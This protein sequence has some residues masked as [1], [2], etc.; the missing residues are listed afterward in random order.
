MTDPFSDFGTPPKR[1]GGPPD[2]VPATPAPIDP[3]TQVSGPVRSGDS[4]T[5]IED[6]RDRINAL[7]VAPPKSTTPVHIFADPG[8]RPS[9]TLIGG[10]ITLQGAISQATP[11]TDDQIKR[12]V[13]ETMRDVH[14]RLDYSSGWIPWA[15][16]NTPANRA[17]V[18]GLLLDT[19]SNKFTIS[20]SLDT[21]DLNQA[22]LHVIEKR[23]REIR[24]F[25]EVITKK[26]KL[27]SLVAGLVTANVN[28]TGSTGMIPELAMAIT[29][30]DNIN[31]DK[32]LLSQAK[33]WTE[34]VNIDA[35]FDSAMALKRKYEAPGIV[36]GGG[37][38]DE[39]G[40][41]LPNPQDF[42][43]AVGQFV[44][45]LKVED[46]QAGETIVPTGSWLEVEVP[47]AVTGRDESLRIA[48]SYSNKK[49][50]NAASASIVDR[51]L[52]TDA[53]QELFSRNQFINAKRTRD[54]GL[55]PEDQLKQYTAFKNVRDAMIQA[56]RNHETSFD[57]EISED[58]YAEDLLLFVEDQATTF[59]GDLD[60][61]VAAQREAEAIANLQKIQDDS[62]A[63]DKAVTNALDNLRSKGS[64]DFD[65]S[66]IDADQIWR[67]G[68]ILL[69]NGEITNTEANISLAASQ[70]AKI[71]EETEESAATFA[72]TIGD[73]TKLKAL[74]RILV[75]QAGRDMDDGLII[76]FDEM[77]EA[78]QFDIMTE[79][80][81]NPQ[82][83][84]LPMELVEGA[85]T[86]A[87]TEAAATE[88]KVAAKEEEARLDAITKDNLASISR[89]ELEFQ[90]QG[91]GG[92]REYQEFLREGGTLDQLEFQLQTKIRNL[93]PGVDVSKDIPRFIRDTL[94]EPEVAPPEAIEGR[95]S[96]F[97]GDIE[98]G[99]RRGLSA[100][101]E[102]LNVEERARR[103]LVS[104]MPAFETESQFKARIA[105]EAAQIDP[106]R[107]PGIPASAQRALVSAGIAPLP[108]LGSVGSITQEELFGMDFGT[109]TEIAQAALDLSGGDPFLQEYLINQAGTKSFDER[110]RS[111][112]QRRYQEA[113]D[114]FQAR[115]GEAVDSSTGKVTPAR[116][117][118][119]ARG[120]THAGLSKTDYL[121]QES[122]ALTSQFDVQPSTVQ[123]RQNEEERTRVQAEDE[124]ERDRD[125]RDRRALR[126]GFSTFSRSA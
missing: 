89:G 91:L 77:S 41:Y 27:D 54:E 23:N 8:H 124:A 98:M 1:S 49:F 126:G 2:R 68:Q 37:V 7:L 71:A 6:L 105:R 5:S 52:M 20:A 87:L 86:R 103:P 39:G 97:P 19:D 63:R 115:F 62:S 46:I 36:E 80:A 31:V 85:H 10:G 111:E 18:I 81:T 96:V 50:D 24:T 118:T 82:D 109:D 13:T 3:G 102:A 30:E 34:S 121:A 112:S 53:E 69:N 57:K 114:V 123:R 17:K 38:D 4:D 94:A 106:R 59:Q 60:D 73:M 64:I 83:T 66:E 116:E 113:E 28:R 100:F 12:L 47:T 11:Y 75:F 35:W 119:T 78:D 72:E 55:S 44:G 16:V 120:P 90:L 29:D 43:M 58:Q 79:I 104:S 40:R 92:S 26:M 110:F 117:Q 32:S 9:S 108:T 74:A 88:G 95:G 65:P 101:D 45:T 22:M 99:T 51:I 70:Q 21:P 14:A 84:P 107:I 67:L 48:R 42:S 122:G 76:D 61:D 56:L 125:E 93:A 33:D 15:T 25:P